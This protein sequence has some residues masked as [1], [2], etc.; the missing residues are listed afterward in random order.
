MVSD[1]LTKALSNTSTDIADN[2]SSSSER[3]QPN[4]ASRSHQHKLEGVS[5]EGMSREISPLRLGAETF[6]CL[7]IQ[8]NCLNVHSLAMREWSSSG[9]VAYFVPAREAQVR[10]LFSVVPYPCCDGALRF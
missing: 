4:W 10:F 3:K 8:P 6:L 9:Q 1:T 5:G 7:G 2:R